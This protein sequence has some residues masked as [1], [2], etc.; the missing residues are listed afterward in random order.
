[1]KLPSP[2]ASLIILL[3]VI[4]STVITVVFSQQKN[5]SDPIISAPDLLVESKI[6]PSYSEKDTDK[7][8]LFD[9]EEVLWGTDPELADT[10]GDGTNDKEEIDSDRNPLVAG[11]DDKNISAEDKIVSQLEEK[12]F[13]KEGLTSQVS[14]SFAENYFKTRNGQD[15]S[16]SQKQILIQNISQEAIEKIKIE[17][18]YSNNSLKTFT[19][20]KNKLIFYA[21]KTFSIQILILA[22]A[23][24][25]SQNP[26]HIKMG[27]YI[28]SL[29]NELMRLEVPQEIVSQ[30]TQL[31]NNYYQ[32]GSIIKDF[33]KEDED[34]LYVMLLLNIYQNIEQD[35]NILS[36]EISNFLS[37]N[38]I[39]IEENQIKIKNE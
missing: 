34:P 24:E 15:L 25:N 5:N 17:P 12:G 27:D 33:V 3:V 35:I 36:N 30:H 21:D 1:M 28:I 4:I 16:E 8:G 37:E 7:D 19:D 14:S 2:R 38:G 32:L 6:S 18:I 9:W 10:D 26:N 13:D 11:P 20:D 23:I 31:A 22:G 29:S 39:I